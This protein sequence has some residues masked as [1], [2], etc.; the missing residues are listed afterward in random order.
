LPLSHSA[1]A[2]KIHST[3][4]QTIHHCFIGCLNPFLYASQWKITFK[5]LLIFHFYG[6]FINFLLARIVFF[7]VIFHLIFFERWEGIFKFPTIFL[8]V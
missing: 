8:Q 1:N 4:K 3:F 6:L 5:F 2:R 7:S